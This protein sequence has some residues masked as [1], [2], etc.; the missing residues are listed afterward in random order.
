MSEK[1]MYKAKYEQVY[2]DAHRYQVMERALG[3][4][5]NLERFIEHGYNSKV[6]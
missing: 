1:N 2:H 4:K 6:I 3:N 5:K